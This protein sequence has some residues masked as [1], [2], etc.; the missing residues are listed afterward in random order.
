MKSTD[1]NTVPCGELQTNL[2][3][4]SGSSLILISRFFIYD[5]PHRPCLHQIFRRL[6]YYVF[7]YL[8]YGTHS[9]IGIK[10]FHIYLFFF[11][12]PNKKVFIK[13]SHILRSSMESI[14]NIFHKSIIVIP[15]LPPRRLL[16]FLFIRY[17][18]MTLST[19]III[20]Y[21]HQIA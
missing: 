13:D 16:Y 9:Y 7:V 3:Q 17:V 6:L 14:S 8:F 5:F 19:H 10:I 4:T 20:A 2:S 12:G 15:I 18:L 1:K 11:V 21:T